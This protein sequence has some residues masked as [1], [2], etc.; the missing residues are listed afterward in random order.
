MGYWSLGKI[1]LRHLFDPF[2]TS[3]RFSWLGWMLN[4]VRDVPN[5]HP[6]GAIDDALSHGKVY[7]SVILR[8]REVGVQS[9]R[10]LGWDNSVRTSSVKRGYKLFI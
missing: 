4:T 9:L 2:V 3:P 1:A 8:V 7:P 10:N 5:I 6:I